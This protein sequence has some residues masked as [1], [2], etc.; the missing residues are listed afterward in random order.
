MKKIL[1]GLFV[2]LGCS[3]SFAQYQRNWIQYNYFNT[4]DHLRSVV[5][6]PVTDHLLMPSRNGGNRVLILDP[7]T[8][9]SLGML[10]LDE[11]IVTGGTYVINQIGVS[12]DGTIYLAN[13]S[14]PQYSPG[15]TFKVY[16]WDNETAAP[17]LVYSD[18]LGDLRFGDSFAV[19][20]SGHE[21]YLYTSGMGNDKVAV[22]K[23]TGAESLEFVTYVTV[24]YAGGARHSISPV[25]AGGEFW[26][27]GDDSS[28]PPAMLMTMDGL[29]KA[30]CPDTLIARGASSVKYVDMGITKMVFA[31]SAPSGS[32]P[33]LRAVKYQ[34]DDLGVITFGYGG[35][36]SDSM[37]LLGGT[38]L[39]P[40]GN[41]TTSLA[42]D[43]R[44]HSVIVL[45]GNNCLASL[46]ANQVFRASTP[47]IDTLYPG[48]VI[49]DG[50]MDFFPSDR[51][52]AT[53]RHQ[54]YLTWSNSKLF[55][56]ITGPTL[57][58]TG[59]P[60]YLY[61]AFDTNPAEGAGL[62]VP[63]VTD[64][65]ITRL[66]FNADVVL[67]IEPWDE[68]GPMVGK[69]YK[70]NGTGWTSTEFDGE[71]AA[72]GALA[73]SKN[74]PLELTEIAAIR[75]DICLG[76]SSGTLG[77]VAYLVNRQ[78]DSLVCAF[79]VQNSTGAVSSL[80]YYFLIDS[81]GQNMYPADTQFVK[82]RQAAAVG[83]CQPQTNPKTGCIL[84]PNYPNP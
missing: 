26:C 69:I 38:G 11:T 22:L 24:P 15:S 68:E 19:A 75:D 65:G 57:L 74:A 6:N 71:T 83:I 3:T 29:L 23:D 46:S 82:V 5:Y 47:R 72:Q 2:I 51:V 64:G 40:N 1:I 53:Q 77:M 31:M 58:G 50:S 79:P 13:L 35:T 44:R 55:T 30:E 59:N 14:A 20:G 61:L 45:A 21:I 80:N 78:A 73:W 56:G 42:Y 12:D 41:S 43:Y 33:L 17:V 39:N 28:H 34:E 70:A 81:L 36:A 8:G 18:A 49:I 25:I 60:N 66:P 7:A 9:D 76:R 48:S 16:R 63:P 62:A 27:K 32:K 54:C 84:A 52:A 10:N 4:S 37:M 67:E